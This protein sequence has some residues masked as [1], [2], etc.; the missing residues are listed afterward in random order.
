[1]FSN[2]GSSRGGFSSRGGRGGGFRFTKRQG[3]APDV[4][5][6]PLGELVAELSNS[7]LEPEDQNQAGTATIQECKSISSY[8]WMNENTPAIMVPGKL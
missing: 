1:M 7:D 4:V 6:H 2:T 3:P 8:N 5:K